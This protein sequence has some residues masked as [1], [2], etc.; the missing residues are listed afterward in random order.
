MSA[1]QPRYIPQHLA[2]KVSDFRVEP[3]GDVSF[4]H[5]ERAVGHFDPDNGYRTTIPAAQY[6]A[7]F[8][9]HYISQNLNE[10]VHAQYGRPEIGASPAEKFKTWLAD[11]AQ[12]GFRWSSE[13]PGR[14]IGSTALLAA[15]AGGAAGALTSSEDESPV[16][17][18][19]M[20]ALL[21]GGA[22]AGLQA[23]MQ[24]F[25][26]R[27][28]PELNKQAFATDD[29]IIAAVMADPNLSQA[30]KM[31]CLQALT[32]L[33]R[34]DKSQLSTMISTLAGGA[35]GV[36]IFKFLGAK[37]LIPLAVGGI[38]GALIGGGP[39]GHRLNPLGQ[40]AL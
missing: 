6:Q 12:K 29:T 34:Q 7:T 20:A 33:S 40:L 36:L 9:P 38:I 5:D 14:A 31:A 28:E 15:L 32:G 10:A 30:Q 26:T 24:G 17:R 25:K 18:G 11:A 23:A 13:T 2:G 4:R 27:P 3:T 19:L 39:Y 1:F 37:G 16:R 22:G 35:A 8:D 21:A